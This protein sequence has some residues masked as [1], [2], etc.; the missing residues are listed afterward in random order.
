MQTKI[1][2]ALRVVEFTHTYEKG[3]RQVFGPKSIK[4]VLTLDTIAE[5]SEI[6]E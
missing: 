6:E 1:S 3:K 2:K 5:Q 4:S